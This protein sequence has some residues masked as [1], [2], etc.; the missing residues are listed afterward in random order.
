MSIRKFDNKF[1]NLD[2][3]IEKLLSFTIST[4]EKDWKSTPH[5]HHFTEIIYVKS[6][7]GKVKIDGE[8]FNINKDDI[9]F[10]NP[11]TQHTEVSS[12]TN[13]LSYYILAIDNISM[14]FTDNSEHFVL[15]DNKDNL[16]YSFFEHLLHELKYD[17]ISSDKLIHHYLSIIILNIC[18]VADS[19]YEIIEEDNIS[20]NL[21]TV[22]QYIDENYEKKITLQQLADI[23][24]I[25][26]YHLGHKF[27][28][29]YGISPIS[30]LNK[31]RLEVCKDLLKNTNYTL[32]E[33]SLILGF[34]SLSYFSQQFKKHENITAQQYR[35]GL[36]NIQNTQS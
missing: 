12:E 9:I 2:N 35:K 20:Y 32:E 5:S 30:Y 31:V 17:N 22:K 23:S 6:G 15:K 18:R 24:N 4:Y 26:K 1:V 25:S 29:V 8:W 7:E 21:H 27:K 36:Q 19:F 28:E 33:I 34:S 14:K 13:P 3:D 11:Y 10:I 16:I